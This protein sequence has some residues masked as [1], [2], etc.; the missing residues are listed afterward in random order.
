M[1]KKAVTP[2]KKGQN[3]KNRLSGNFGRTAWWLNLL[4]LPISLS[5][6]TS[7]MGLTLVVGLVIGLLA[8]VLLY[9]VR[10][11]K[12]KDTKDAGIRMA[13]RVAIAV[14]AI[15]LLI[16]VLLSSYFLWDGLLREKPPDIVGHTVMLFFLLGLGCVG[17]L[18][19]FLYS[20][21]MPTISLQ[22]RL[23]GLLGGPSLYV[24]FCV[25][26]V[27]TSLTMVLFYLFGGGE[28]VFLREKFLQRGLIPPLCLTL[29]YW[30][31][32]LLT[33]KYYLSFRH[34]RGAPAGSAISSLWEEYL[35]NRKKDKLT[36]P[37]P[38]D[39]LETVWQ[40]NENFYF[41]PRYINWAI[42]ILGFIGTVLG[43][44]L[45]A[46]EIGNIVGTTSVNVG[47]GINRAMEPLSIAF[48]TT[49][50]A[51]SLSVF[52]V[53]L[54][55]TLQKWEEQKFLFLENQLAQKI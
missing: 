29:F 48:D 33:G 1:K 24:S 17:I 49:L 44:S 4:F 5:A 30:E 38:G 15:V 52:L 22:Q 32:V 40:V 6:L 25:A 18:L 21:M 2:A 10:F 16:T 14:N 23:H 35:D 20:E 19:R 50:I 51:L 31:L 46:G 39:F 28:L 37:V 7:L 53:F 36:K 9:A 11:I 13:M 47:E 41:V 55:T 8:D 43:I 45:A 42:P 34:L 26:A 12:V 54:Y 27:L 3:Q